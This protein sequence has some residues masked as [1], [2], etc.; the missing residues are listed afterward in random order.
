MESEHA[1]RTK[2]E[3]LNVLVLA[4]AAL[5]YVVLYKWLGTLQLEL[6]HESEFS[7]GFF[8]RVWPILGTCL[9]AA[10]AG[11]GL[12][13]LLRT[14]RPLVYGLLLGGAILLFGLVT[15]VSA[16]H[17][18]LYMVGEMLLDTLL[19]AFVAPAATLLLYRRRDRP[20]PNAAT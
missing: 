5:T 4:A 9:I 20:T 11:G 10:I 3:L 16:F 14:Q 19:A 18:H 13:A 12:G 1:A 2:A 8:L 17:L 6:V 15:I 7:R